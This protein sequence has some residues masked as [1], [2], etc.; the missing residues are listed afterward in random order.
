MGE[1]KPILWWVRRDMRL[2]D[3][4]GLAAAGES[5]RPVIPVFLLDEV[6]ETTGACPRWRAGLGA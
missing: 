5:G 4:P 6:L 3:N 1:G 2:G